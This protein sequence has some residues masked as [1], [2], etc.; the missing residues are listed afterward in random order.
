MVAS[1]ISILMIIIGQGSLLVKVS[2]YLFGL[3]NSSLHPELDVWLE[4]DMV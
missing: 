4:I 1:N 2:Y 3:Y